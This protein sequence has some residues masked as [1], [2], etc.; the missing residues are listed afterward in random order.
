MAGHHR[1]RKFRRATAQ[2]RGTQAAEF[3]DDSANATAVPPDAP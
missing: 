1:V 2:V 3:A